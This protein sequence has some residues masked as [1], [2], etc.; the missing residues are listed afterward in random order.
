MYHKILRNLETR[1]IGLRGGASP[2]GRLIR[3][4]RGSLLRL[5]G[6]EGVPLAELPRWV[7]MKQSLSSTAQARLGQLI[8][9]GSRPMALT[10]ERV[11]PKVRSMKFECRVRRWCSTAK[12]RKLVS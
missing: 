11:S 3:V 8:S 2:L 5:R 12:R 4:E 1:R 9:P 6:E 7:T 10:R